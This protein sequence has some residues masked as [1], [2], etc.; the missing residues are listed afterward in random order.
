MLAIRRAQAASL[1]W[2]LGFNR[3]EHYGRHSS[4]PSSDCH[5]LAP[6]DRST[7][8]TW[9]GVN[10]GLLICAILDRRGHVR[11]SRSRGQFLL[12]LLRTQ[13]TVDEVRSTLTRTSLLGYAPS[14]LF[15]GDGSGGVLIRIPELQ[16][17]EIVS[18][19]SVVTER[20]T[21]TMSRRARYAHDTLRD[22]TGSYLDSPIRLSTLLSEHQSTKHRWYSTC[23]HGS[24]F[25]T[26][27]SQIV[28]TDSKARRATLYYSDGPPCRST[29]YPFEL[30]F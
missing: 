24:G 18:E 23:C 19:V 26:V 11:G 15:A 6:I 22:A 27:S 30:R 8:G 29:Y 25:G 16:E 13:S 17:Q 10:R 3:D 1:D 9:V 28:A 4:P 5:Y 20:G 21:D 14:T 12:D 2:V 7:G